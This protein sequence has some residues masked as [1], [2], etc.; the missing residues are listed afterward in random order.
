MVRDVGDD[1]GAKEV[2]RERLYRW[3]EPASPGRDRSRC[4]GTPKTSSTVR[5]F[6][7][8]LRSCARPKL[9]MLGSG[10]MSL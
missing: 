6:R 10:D 7:L 8:S 4:T 5:P 9:I 2:D 3:S 1:V